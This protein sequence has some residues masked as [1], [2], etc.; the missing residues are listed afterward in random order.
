MRF[1]HVVGR[2]PEKHPHTSSWKYLDSKWNCNSQRVVIQVLYTFH[3]CLIGNWPTLTLKGEEKLH[4][5]RIFS[6]QR[7]SEAK[8]FHVTIPPGKQN[9]N[10]NV[11]SLLTVDWNTWEDT[12]AVLSC[13]TGRQTYRRQTMVFPEVQS[14]GGRTSRPKLHD[15]KF[16]LTAR[17]K[18]SHWQQSNKA[19]GCLES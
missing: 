15:R 14:D 2:E 10:L 4:I 18:S 11:F 9:G 17:K 16:W 13:L 7:T 6:W 5:I 3:Y 12:S 8:D 19:T 1:W